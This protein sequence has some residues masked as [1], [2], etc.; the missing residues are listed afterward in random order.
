MQNVLNEENIFTVI[1]KLFDK[2]NSRDAK[3]GVVNL[4]G[5][6][7]RYTKNLIMSFPLLWDSSLSIDTGMMVAKANERNVVNMLQLLFAA[8]NLEFTK[9][10]NVSGADI[11]AKF[12]RDIDPNMDLNDLIDWLDKMSGSDNKIN[13]AAYYAKLGVNEAV[14]NMMQQF[15]SQTTFKKESIN[16]QSLND[17]LVRTN[18]LGTQTVFKAPVKLHEANK[19]TDNSR[20]GMLKDADELYKDRRDYTDKEA[21]AQLNNITRRVL[22]SADLKKINAMEPTLIII[23]YNVINRKIANINDYQIVDKKSFLAGVK[24][25]VIPVE[26]MDIA[27]RFVS[28][29]KTKLSLKNLIRATTG[30]ISFVKDFL[31]CLDKIKIDAKNTAKRGPLANYWSILEKRATKNNLRKL[32][33]GGNDGAAITTIALSQD[34]VNYMRNVYR[35]D[36]E[37]ISNAK[38][39]L[40]AYNLLG[41]MICDEAEES[42]KVLYDGYNDFEVFSYI[43]LQ[44]DVSDRNYRKVVNLLDQERR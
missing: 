28:K 15:N 31:L 27:E 30:E 6:I 22:S 19:S 38:M 36:I 44:R 10:D 32:Q 5:S 7:S 18:P 14:K 2:K 39:I 24:S 16:P 35:F 37:N 34:T 29:D 8:V 20:Y 33:R 11:I 25:R 26:S 9:S 3:Q 23:N 21:Q 40:N 1:D 13:N 43:S 12:Y 17:Y 41:I 4:N 42:V